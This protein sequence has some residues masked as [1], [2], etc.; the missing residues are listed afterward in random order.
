[1]ARTGNF[2]MFFFALLLTATMAQADT[3]K[4][5]SLESGM[6][7]YE[8]TGGG[9]VM[10]MVSETKGHSTLYFKDYGDVTFEEQETTTT[11]SGLVNKVDKAHTM[12]KIESTTVYTVDFERKIINKGTDPIAAQYLASGKN[13]SA[14]SEN[15]LQKMGGKKIGTEK[16]LGYPCEVWSIMG[17]KQWLYKGQVP[18]RVEAEIMGMKSGMVA[19]KASFNKSIPQS[20]FKLPDYKIEVTQDYMSQGQALQQ[21]EEM[22]DFGAMMGD[23]QAQLNA[24]PDMGD[25]EQKAMMMQMISNSDSGKSKF[26]QEKEQMPKMLELMKEMESCL[27]NASSQADADRCDAKFTQLAGEMGLNDGASMDDDDEPLVWN[28]NTKKQVLSEL[29]EEIKS[30]EQIMPCIESAQNVMDMMK[31]NQGQMF[32]GE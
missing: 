4:R 2:L 13:I 27:S 5:Y 29:R 7:E 25:A 15:Q 30:L 14:D 32:D 20:K 17:G 28:K 3:V 31:C 11:M 18:L 23:I 6:V 8:V 26:Q 10:G 22:N 9:N 16:V 1:M 19:V 21:G 12:K 24:N